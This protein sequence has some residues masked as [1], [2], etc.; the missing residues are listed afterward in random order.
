MFKN[1]KSKIF[2]YGF[3]FFSIAFLGFILINVF[4]HYIIKYIH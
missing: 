2:I 1:Q 3:I 4:E